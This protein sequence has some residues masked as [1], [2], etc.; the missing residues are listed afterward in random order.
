MAEFVYFYYCIKFHDINI[1][2]YFTLRGHFD[3][4]FSTIMN[5]IA[6]N[7]LVSALL[8]AYIH[9]SVEYFTYEWNFYIIELCILL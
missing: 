4:K 5:N 9:I 7:I 2:T 8:S 6:M 1:L 3:F